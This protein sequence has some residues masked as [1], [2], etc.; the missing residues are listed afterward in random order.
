ML[1]L[2]LEWGGTTYPWDSVTIIGLFCGAGGLFILFLGWEYFRKEEAMLPPSLF[3]NRVMSCAIIVSAMTQGGVYLTLYYLPIWFQVVKDLSPTDSGLHLLP[4]VA[5]MAVS[6]V[7][8]GILGTSFSAFSPS[9]L[10]FCSFENWLLHP[11]HYY[12][13]CSSFNCY[14]SHDNT[15]TI[16]RSCN[17]DLLSA[18]RWRCSG[19]NSTT[20]F[21]CCSSCYI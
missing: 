19:S 17:L 14:W 12:W 6:T 9:L 10:I 11:L 21:H 1:L 13:C 3:R 15:Y 4:S 2:A 8:T 16:I 7:L 20:T 5:S 18:S